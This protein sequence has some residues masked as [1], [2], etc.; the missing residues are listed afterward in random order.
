MCSLLVQKMTNVEKVI[1]VMVLVSYLEGN[2]YN[3]MSIYQYTCI[4]RIYS[5]G[6]LL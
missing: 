3:I 1:L 6:V 5:M 2:Y 4:D